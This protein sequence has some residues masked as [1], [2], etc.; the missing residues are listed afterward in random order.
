[1]SLAFCFA[2]FWVMGTGGPWGVCMEVLL[3]VDPR[4][5]FS[6]TA[7]LTMKSGEGLYVKEKK[8]GGSAV[9]DGSA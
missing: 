5:S 8:N 2:L 1:M 7:A 6:V 3:I 9:A 4:V